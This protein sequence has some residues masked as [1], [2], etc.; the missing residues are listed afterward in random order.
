MYKTSLCDGLARGHGLY[1]LTKQ[2]YLSAISF[3]QS[4]E[5]PCYLLVLEMLIALSSYVIGLL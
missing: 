5:F 1:L 2:V 3:L 4:A